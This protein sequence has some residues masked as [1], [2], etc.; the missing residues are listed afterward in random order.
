MRSTR[1]TATSRRS[2]RAQKD[3][4]KVVE[5]IYLSCLNRLPTEKEIAA[6]DLDMAPTAG[7]G[8]GLGVG[9]DQQSGVFV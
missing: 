3:D 6:I 1:R 2:S 7:S 4:K 9:V 8:A 5:E